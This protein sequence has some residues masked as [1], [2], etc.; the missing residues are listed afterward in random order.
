MDSSNLNGTY[1][2]RGRAAITE[3]GGYASGEAHDAL[4]GEPMHLDRLD[5]PLALADRILWAHSDA[6]SPGC[7]SVPGWEAALADLAS[8]LLVRC[9]ALEQ[10]VAHP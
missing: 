6:R 9:A 10:Q 3:P 8:D 5:V 7:F 1:S 2:P 4:T